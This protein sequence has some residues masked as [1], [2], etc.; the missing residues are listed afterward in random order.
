MMDAEL[1]KWARFGV[2]WLA[3]SIFVFGNSACD[4]N[5]ISTPTATNEKAQDSG[6]RSSTLDRTQMKE[7]LHTFSLILPDSKTGRF[8]AGLHEIKA[9]DA[10]SRRIVKL[11]KDGLIIVNWNAK[12]PA[13]WWAYEN[14]APV[15]GG[16]MLI[17]DG[18]ESMSVTEVTAD[19]AKKIM[20]K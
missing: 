14:D 19:E 1:S 3:A 4:K 10:E 9:E 15:K 16:Y 7:D 8:T 12:L 20:A 2:C 13:E 18:K 5:S 17:R 6:P 11:I